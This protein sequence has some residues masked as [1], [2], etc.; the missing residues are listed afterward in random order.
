[1]VAAASIGFS[2]TSLEI[3]P[4]AIVTIIVSPMA[5]EI[6]STNAATMPEMAAGNTTRVATCILEEASA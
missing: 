3:T 1:M 2:V 4:P 6:P 5:R